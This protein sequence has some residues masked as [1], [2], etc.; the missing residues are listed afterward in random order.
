MT[1]CAHAVDGKE[2]ALHHQQLRLDKTRIEKALA[3]MELLQPFGTAA[4]QPEFS[5]DD[6]LLADFPWAPSTHGM[7]QHTW[8]ATS[9]QTLCQACVASHASLPSSQRC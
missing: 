7:L 6:I 2:L 3:K 9:M 1:D 4:G 5:V 8:P